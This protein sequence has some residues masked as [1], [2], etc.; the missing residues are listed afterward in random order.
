MLEPTS[1]QI[2]HIVNKPLLLERRVD[3]YEKFINLSKKHLK[4]VYNDKLELEVRDVSGLS[5]AVYMVSV[6]DCS[7][8]N[9]KI[10]IR[11]F[12][13]KASNIEME[14]QVFSLASEK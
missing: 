10:I 4:P 9:N 1:E 13:S 12:E 3:L 8:L 14:N 11:F 5:N 6:K 2:V 7:D